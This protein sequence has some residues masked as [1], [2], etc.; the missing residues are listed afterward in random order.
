MR[1]LKALKPLLDC[2]VLLT[3]GKDKED[4]HLV[5][6]GGALFTFNAKNKYE[7]RRCY[8]AKRINSVEYQE[9]FTSFVIHE[10]KCR[11]LMPF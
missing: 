9:K 10:E 5:W 1:Q 2:K 11:E 3:D 8:A 7:M 6:Q 4:R